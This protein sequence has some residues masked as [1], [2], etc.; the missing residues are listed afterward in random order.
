[1][2]TN[3][4]IYTDTT[5]PL[6]ANATFNGKVWDFVPNSG[7]TP[8]DFTFYRA[9]FAADQS[10]TANILYSADGAQWFLGATATVSSLTATHLAVPITTRFYQAQL[11]NGSLSQGH[12]LVATAPTAN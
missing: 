6:A 10:G 3:S 1:M 4:Y 2:S 11:V 9:S 8:V 12:V 5:T 7:H